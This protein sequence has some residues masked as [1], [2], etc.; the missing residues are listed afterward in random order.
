MERNHE[1]ALGYRP[2]GNVA[3]QQTRPHRLKQAIGFALTAV[4]C[5]AVTDEAAAQ[6]GRSYSSGGHSSSSGRSYSS[7]GHSSSSSSSGHSSSSSGGHSSSSS[8]SGHSS[9][10]GGRS[11]SSGSGTS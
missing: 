8:S 2:S 5:L 6:K 7:S 4:L 3:L 1:Y 10:S 11:Y 9:S